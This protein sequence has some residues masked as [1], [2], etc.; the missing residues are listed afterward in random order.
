MGSFNRS[1]QNWLK[2]PVLYAAAI[3][4]PSKLKTGGGPYHVWCTIHDVHPYQNQKRSIFCLVCWCKLMGGPSHLGHTLPYV[5]YMQTC[6]LMRESVSSPLTVTLW[7]SATRKKQM[8]SEIF[9][10]VNDC[11]K[12]TKS[13][14]NYQNDVESPVISWWMWLSLPLHCTGHKRTGS[15]MHKFIYQ[16]RL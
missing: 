6:Q 2:V 1:A 9:I 7:S 16:E 4:V 10:G 12:T 5:I 14:E 11:L 15:Y 13:W 8:S 3:V